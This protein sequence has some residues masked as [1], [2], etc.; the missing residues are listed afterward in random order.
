[1]NNVVAFIEPLFAAMVRLDGG[2][3][4]GL[5]FLYQ[6]VEARINSF[7]CPNTL[8]PRTDTPKLTVAMA[9]AFPASNSV[10]GAGG[11]QMFRTSHRCRFES[12]QKQSYLSDFM[13]FFQTWRHR[14]MEAHRPAEY[15]PHSGRSLNADTYV[16]RIA[17]V[18]FRSGR[19]QC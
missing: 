18:D 9:A 16:P 1:M 11:Y 12:E 4:A 7:R 15:E 10:L 2:V 19:F 17:E 5:P 3:V 8:R 13:V 14:E 6:L